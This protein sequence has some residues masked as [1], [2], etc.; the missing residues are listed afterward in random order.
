M[1]TSNANR[2]GKK[3]AR[4]R[5]SIDKCNANRS[6]KEVARLRENMNNCNAYRGGKELV[7]NTADVTAFLDGF[8][9]DQNSFSNKYDR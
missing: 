1:N 2:G 8:E 4:L 3:I 9:S 5:E 7:C 6:G